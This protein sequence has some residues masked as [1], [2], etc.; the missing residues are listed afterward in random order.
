M[1]M[2]EFGEIHEAWTELKTIYDEID[3]L[4]EPEGTIELVGSDAHAAQRA[5]AR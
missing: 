3:A 4:N 2:N 5:S 1:T